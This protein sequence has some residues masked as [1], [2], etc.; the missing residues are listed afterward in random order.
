MKAPKAMFDNSSITLWNKVLHNRNKGCNSKFI[1]HATLFYW[2]FYCLWTHKWYSFIHMVLLQLTK[3][4]PQLLCLDP[5]RLLFC[6]NNIFVTFLLVCKYLFPTLMLSDWVG[7]IATMGQQTMAE[8]QAK[9]TRIQCH[10]SVRKSPIHT[11]L[12]MIGAHL[13]HGSFCHQLPCCW[14]AGQTLTTVGTGITLCQTLLAAIEDQH[15]V[16]SARELLTNT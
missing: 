1:Y 2:W 10:A 4:K 12:R 14:T 9:I 3:V 11:M 5:D 7:Y 16:C 15:S 13:S 8:N 6:I